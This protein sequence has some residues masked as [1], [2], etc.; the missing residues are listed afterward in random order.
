MQLV[1]HEFLTLDGVMQGPGAVD[2]DRADGFDR[3][4]WIVPFDGDEAWGAVDGWF[5]T[6]DAILLGRTTYDMMQSYWTR[7]TDPDNHTATALNT[8][9][10]YLVSSTDPS[11]TWTNTTRLTGD[12]I[13]AVSA[14]KARDGGELQVHGSWQL[15]HTLHAARLVDEYRLLIFP[16]SV[17]PGKRLFSPTAP[18]TGFQTLTSQSFP[19]GI[20]YLALRPT[21]FTQ[22]SFAVLDG[23][24]SANL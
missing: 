15:A 2:E 22:G 6:T 4:G 21:P 12:L 17:G 9:P 7:V 5:R 11:P 24:E 16:V 8:L 3:G 1:V 20:T 13:E 19:S 10:K 18:A 14:L 23:K